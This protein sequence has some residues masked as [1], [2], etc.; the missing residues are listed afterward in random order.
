ME[1]KLLEGV[2]IVDITTFVTGPLTTRTL[3]DC[4]A[5]VIKLD[6]RSTGNPGFG[7]RAGVN[8]HDTSKLSITLNFRNPKGLELAHSLIARSDVVVE[9]HAA[10]TLIRRGLGYNALKKIKPDIIMLSSCMQGQTG[11]YS[12]HAAFGH[13]LT[14]LSG[15]NHITGWPDREPGW[16]G[17]YT[18]VIAPRYNIIAIL[19]ALDYRRQTGK[20]QFL[21]MSQS[22]AGVQFMAPLILDCAVNKRVANRMGNEHPTAA[23]HNAYRCSGDDMW[24][25]IAVFTDEEWRSFCKVIKKPSLLKNP[26]FSTLIARKENEEELDRVVNEWTSSR[27]AQEVMTLMQK[28]GVAAGVAGTAEAELGTDPQLESRHFYWDLEHPQVGTYRTAAGPHFLLSKTEYNLRRAHLIGEDNDY[29]FKHILGL[30][31]ERIAELVSEG[32]IS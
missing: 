24:C 13:Q 10:G 19:A 8:Q 5:E 30:S 25:A 9:N 28:A 27:S 29:V 12:A 4:G 22:E 18:D 31:D 11:P 1:T 15:F 26:K 6:T 23:P 32:V 3:S 7:A 14:A 21:D 16:L 20:G 17:P 2:R